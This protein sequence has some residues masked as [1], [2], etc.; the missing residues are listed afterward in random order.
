MASSPY[1]SVADIHNEEHDDTA[2]AKNV[3]LNDETGEP[4]SKTNPLPVSS[5]AHTSEDL[6]GKG[7]IT[8]GTT[9]VE[10]IFS[11]VTESIIITSDI[12]NTGIIYVGKSDVLSDGSNAISQLDI[13]QG[14]TMDYDDTLNPIFIVAD[15][16]SQTV[17]A[18]ATK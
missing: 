17:I 14:I 8:V 3:L 16:A 15:T 18:G 7:K 10:L 2:E 5:T 12:S 13:S 1:K 6:E 11:G 4:I 9:A